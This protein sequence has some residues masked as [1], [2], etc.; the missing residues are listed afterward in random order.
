[1]VCP[2]RYGL[3]AGRSIA[4]QGWAVIAGVVALCVLA[5]FL[6]GPDDPRGF[7][8]IIPA[9]VGLLIISTMTTQSGWRWGKR[10]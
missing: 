3:G 1:M 7:A 6:F 8:I 5:F 9:I 10:D 2:K 4:W